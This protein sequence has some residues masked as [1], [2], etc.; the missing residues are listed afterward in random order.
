MPV[1]GVRVIRTQVLYSVRVPAGSD[2]TAVTV[3]GGVELR[4]LSG[5]INAQTTN[6]GIDGRE[7]S[8]SI[9]ASTT[10]GG[11]EVDTQGDAFFVAFPTAPGALAARTPGA[12]EARPHVLVDLVDKVVLEGDD[13]EGRGRHGDDEEEPDDGGDELGGE[14]PAGRGEPRTDRAGRRGRVHGAGLRT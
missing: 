12:H 8:G 7:L 13:G 9:E 6:G 4:G 11:V 5:R 1:T 14:R 3:N 2:V 10:N